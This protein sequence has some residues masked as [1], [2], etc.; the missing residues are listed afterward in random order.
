MHWQSHGCH[1]GIGIEINIL[2]AEGCSV[3]VKGSRAY[4]PHALELYPRLKVLLV[5]VSAAELRRRLKI[6]GRETA[7]K[8]QSR[9]A[10]NHLL[11]E[12]SLYNGTDITV[13]HNGGLLE[14]AGELFVQQLV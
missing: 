13:I 6:R 8:I 2:L 10:Q 9:L 14:A 7:E 12:E 1:Y 4:L 11:H 5:D 3:V